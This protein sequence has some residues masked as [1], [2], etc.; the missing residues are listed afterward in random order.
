MRSATT[1]KNAATYVP[2]SVGGSSPPG[3][4]L[5]E[6]RRRLPELRA[7]WPL[8]SCPTAGITGSSRVR[9]VTLRFCGNTP[10]RS[11]ASPTPLRVQRST[12]GRPRARPQPP[13]EP[14]HQV[15]ALSPVRPL[16]EP[17][18]PRINNEVAGQG[19]KV[20]KMISYS[21]FSDVRERL[22]RL[23]IGRLGQKEG[24]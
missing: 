17:L 14:R 24:G 19:Q 2:A 8:D 5:S 16:Q 3:K 11:S 20:E 10:G 21:N 4:W 9:L 7:R 13:S 22:R 15:T 12:P 18:T 6:T 23:L 1:A